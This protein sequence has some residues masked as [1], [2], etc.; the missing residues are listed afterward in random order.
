VARNTA[1]AVTQGCVPPWSP[2]RAAMADPALQ[3][4]PVTQGSA[5]MFDASEKSSTD[6]CE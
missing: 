4:M 1:S 2:S 6:V 5:G 3:V